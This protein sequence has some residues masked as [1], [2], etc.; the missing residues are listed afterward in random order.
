MAQII[1]AHPGSGSSAQTAL[2]GRRLG[3]ARGDDPRVRKLGIEVM[4]GWGMTE[5]SP[6]A[7]ISKVTAQQAASSED[8]RL[9]VLAKQGYPLPL[10]DVRSVATRAKRR[11][12][13][14]RR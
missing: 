2:D 14:R 4:Q 12:M 9:R 13:A 11:G 1:A 5:T 6:L 10:V 7:T 8:E 3:G